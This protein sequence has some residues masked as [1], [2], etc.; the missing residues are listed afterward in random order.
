M[1]T[2]QN[3][4]VIWLKEGDECGPKIL[5]KSPYYVLYFHVHEVLIALPTDGSVEGICILS[6]CNDFQFYV[7]NL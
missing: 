1:N 5:H 6:F 4:T 2:F 3:N 7:V